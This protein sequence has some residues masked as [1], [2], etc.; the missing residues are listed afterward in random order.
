[1]RFYT[2][3]IALVI[4]FS[5]LSQVNDTIYYDT[6]WDK[7]KKDKAVYYRP[8]PL[9]KQDGLYV[10]KDY[11]INGNLQMEAFSTSL[12][13][14]VFQG[15]VI[16]YY[17]N[18][19]ISLKQTFDKGKT[20]G[21]EVSYFRDGTLMSSGVYKN[22]SKHD[23]TFYLSSTSRDKTSSVNN[24]NLHAYNTYY[25]S[26]KTM[27][28]QTIYDKDRNY[29]KSI[30]F[31]KKGDTI[32]VTKEYNKSTNNFT[33]YSKIYF[34]VNK[35][36]NVLDIVF[37]LYQEYKNNELNVFLRD[38][39]GKTLAKGRYKNGRPFEG[40]FFKD[41]RLETYKNGIRDGE[42][43]FYDEIFNEIASGV[44]RN[45]AEYSGSFYIPYSREIQEFVNGKLVA[46]ITKNKFTNQ[47]YRCV[48]DNY[49][50]IEG[51]YYTRSTLETY[52]AG[53]RIKQIDLNYDT[54]KKKS[55]TYYDKGDYI[56]TKKVYFK[57]DTQYEV[58]L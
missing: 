48:F 53:K 6:Y 40:Q 37:M 31:D 41:N 18:G 54:G 36:A 38:K 45:G 11:F 28:R 20:I 26:T 23:G 17:D 25:E 16:W 44:Y 52:K 22:G 13:N 56:I 35:N 33:G 10:V 58:H 42:A 46:K 47:T 49:T 5:C 50:P 24:G 2:C 29:E 32:A 3:L 55:I 34:K 12:K 27:A 57:E 39:D 8:L 9:K 21:N 30:Y 43:I 15:D 19:Q 51:V 4:T 14:D 1:M 7:T